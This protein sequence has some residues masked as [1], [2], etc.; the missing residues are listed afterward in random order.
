MDDE[1]LKNMMEQNHTSA[2]GWA[3]YCCNGDQ[4]EAADV[5]HS[6]YVQILEKGRLAF[7]GKSSFKTWLFSVIRNTS[8]KR[9]F[10][11]SHRLRK[12]QNLVFGLPPAEEKG[13][14]GRFY[15]NEVRNWILDLFGRLSKRQ[16]QVLQ[17]A[18]YHN[19]TLAEAAVVM[20]V[21]VGSAR[22]HYERGKVRLRAEM[23]K[24]GWNNE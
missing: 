13:I 16:R 22:T 4:E 10:Q 9:R 3:L 19:L 20:G 15:E 18:F 7:S 14:E 8:R 2:F 5:L 17:L 11:V 1:S 12:L 24:V 21:S 6:V 23:Q